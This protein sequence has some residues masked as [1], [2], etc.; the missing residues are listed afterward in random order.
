MT[1]LL[2]RVISAH[3]CRSTH[4]HIAIS[5]LTLLKGENAQEWHDHLLVLHDDLLKGAKAPDAEFKD[6]KNHVLHISEGEWGGARD[7]AL[8]WYAKSVMALKAKRWSDA[9]YALGVMSHYYADPIQPF[10]TGQTE[11]EGAIHRAV[12]WSIAKSRD[13]ILRRIEAKG[14]PTVPTGEGA[15]FVSDMVRAGAEKSHPHYQ[16]FLD[17]YNI[18]AGAKVPE[19]GLDD[20][21]LDVI[22]DLVA[23]ATSGLAAIYT[24]AFEEAGVVPPKSS[25]TLHGFLSTLDIPIRWITS[26]LEDANDR[27]IVSAMYKEL[28]TTGKVIK[29]LPDDDKQI[30]KMH[31]QQ[32]LR[33]PLKELD[34]QR[35]R[36]IGEK[37]IA[38]TG[39]SAAPIAQVASVP[40]QEHKQVESSPALATQQPTHTQ[41]P[42]AQQPIRTPQIEPPKVDVAAIAELAQTPP[43]I[44]TKIDKKAAREAAKQA[45]IAEKQRIVQDKS[46]AASGSKAEKEAAAQV[47][48]EAA[49]QANA[50]KEAELRAK[51]EAEE[52]ARLEAIELKEKNERD[53]QAAKAEKQKAAEEAKAAKL[54]EQAEKQNEKK[55]LRAQNNDAE[56]A[57]AA[58]LLKTAHNTA[59][60]REAEQKQASTQAEKNS[61]PEKSTPSEK[62]KFRVKAASNA[63]APAK[64][65]TAKS[66][67]AL[68]ALRQ[69]WAEEEET[70]TSHSETVYT[71]SD[72]EDVEDNSAPPSDIVENND[73]DDDCYTPRTGSRRDPLSNESPIVDAP[74]I[75]KK[76]AARM[77]SVG[78]HTV[79]DFITAKAKDLS[80]KLGGGYMSPTALIDWQD[81]ALLMIDMPS[82]RVHDAQILVGAGIRCVEDLAESSSRDL[83]QSATSF[84]KTKDGARIAQNSGPLDHEEVYDWIEEAQA[85]FA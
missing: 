25:L 69:S 29:K 4:H 3:R 15:G 74:S 38:R 56:S 37:H 80:A 32:V 76:T 9:A 79:G 14:Y 73:D 57:E 84:L 19:D 16:T 18:D 53:V 50:D 45:K 26:K 52:K 5:A 41:A 27:R 28:T 85:A 10:H 44:A 68:E 22:A 8:E 20:T 77:K 33:M 43:P 66:F 7:A 48:F 35:M 39:S 59:K 54:A 62:P 75:G 55:R 60:Q 67:D 58:A 81:Q 11:E 51:A 47:K 63:P 64:E 2:F 36:K 13:E 83:F 42:A 23:Y 31:A 24:R 34:A 49:A 65:E 21:L 40:T 6:F 46:D 61:E 17:H 12:E 30:R 1:S 82:L 72:Y 70:D 71:E 78:I